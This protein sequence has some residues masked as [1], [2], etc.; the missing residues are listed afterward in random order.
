M[1]TKS[2]FEAIERIKDWLLNA[3]KHFDAGRG[4]ILFGPAGT[5]KDHLLTAMLVEAIKAGCFPR[6]ECDA[7][8]E[9]QVVWANGPDWISANR[10]VVRTNELERDAKAKYVKAR[11]L[12]L[13][14]VCQSGQ[15]LKDY[16]RQTLYSILDYRYSHCKPTWV[17][18]NAAN[19]A[20][21]SE[22]LGGDV[23]DRLLG[24]SLV[25]PCVWES[26]RKPLNELGQSDD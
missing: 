22:M 4:V 2:H 23:A 10:D 5:G 18:T 8:P 9:K 26:Y 25:V 1:P 14:D 12:L 24:D 19:R 6:P 16:Q 7:K 3:R 21:L 15:V 17:S 20:E 13:S 11:L